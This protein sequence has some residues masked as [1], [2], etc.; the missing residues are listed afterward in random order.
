MT[1]FILSFS[2]FAVIVIITDLFDTVSCFNLPVCCL[3]VG[4]L[5][6]C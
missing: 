3:D 4:A 2:E 6:L 5:F 1:V